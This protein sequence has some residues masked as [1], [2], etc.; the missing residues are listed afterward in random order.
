MV[1][2]KEMYQPIQHR[3]TSKSIPNPLT[4]NISSLKMVFYIKQFPIMEVL[5]NINKYR[6]GNEIRNK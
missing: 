5:Q 4:S 1:H 2:A 3:L 6:M